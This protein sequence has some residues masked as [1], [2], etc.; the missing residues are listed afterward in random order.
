M[1]YVA[2]VVGVEAVRA[3]DVDVRARIRLDVRMLFAVFRVAVRDG[4][5]AARVRDTLRS[6]VLIVRGRIRVVVRADTDLVSGTELLLRV[7]VVRTGV[8]SR[9][10][11]IGSD[12]AGGFVRDAVAFLDVVVFADF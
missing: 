12:V 10:R 11:D 7:F 6:V 2:D 1:S 3:M 4:A 8:V 5:V 9:L